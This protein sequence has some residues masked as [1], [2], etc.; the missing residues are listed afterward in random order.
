M[1]KIMV[2]LCVSACLLWPAMVRAIA[3]PEVIAARNLEAGYI[4]V[5]EVVSVHADGV[6]AYFVLKV[7]HVVKGA[8]EIKKGDTLKV[9]TGSKPSPPSQVAS[10]TQGV[11]PVTVTVGSLVMLYAD[12][13]DAHPGYFNP[14]LQGLSVVAIGRP[15]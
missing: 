1:L 9:L 4:L 11:L 15:S 10:Q 7:S 8:A 5:G 2:G 3:P 12:R 6:P 14:L 13:S